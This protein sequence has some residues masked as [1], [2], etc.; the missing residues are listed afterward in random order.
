MNLINRELLVKK[1]G[2]NQV[3]TA[4]KIGISYISLWRKTNGITEF[5]ESEIENLVDLFGKEILNL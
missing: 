3:K 1:I 2:E 5:T 4:E